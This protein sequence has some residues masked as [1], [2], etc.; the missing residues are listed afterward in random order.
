MAAREQIRNLFDLRRRWD[1]LSLG[2]NVLFDVSN[3][4]TNF[5]SV[6]GSSKKAILMVC[7]G[8]CL[9]I[10]VVAAISLCT[11]WQIRTREENAAL[12]QFDRE[13]RE[14]GNPEE[15]VK[16]AGAGLEEKMKE[17]KAAVED[18]VEKKMKGIEGLVENMIKK[19]EEGK[20]D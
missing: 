19:V 7:G 15:G 12:Q 10:L 17:I 20:K 13:H 3:L 6:L 5:L 1:A 9:G 11:A 16:E 2:M 8:V 14:T 18:I 4:T